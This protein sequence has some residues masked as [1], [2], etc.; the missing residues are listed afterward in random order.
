MRENLGLDSEEKIKEKD[1]KKGGRGKSILK[2]SMAI[3][4][5]VADNSEAE[6]PKKAKK[7]VMFKSWHLFDY[8]K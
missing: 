2:T 5:K 4:K 3:S 7:S 1:A 6:K 8:P